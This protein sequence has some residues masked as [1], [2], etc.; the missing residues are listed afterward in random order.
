MFPDSGEA[1]LTVLLVFVGVTFW[2][3]SR[4]RESLRQL[5]VERPAAFISQ[6][7]AIRVVFTIGVL[8]AVLA[9]M[10]FLRGDGAM[11]AASGLGEG[12]SWFVAFDVG[13][14]LDVLAAVWVLSAFRH[15]C[16][17]AKYT[18]HR[19]MRIFARSRRP[20]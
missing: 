19:V 18:A 14:Y 20:V 17:G 4:S 16:G 13:T 7:T 8:A 9:L 2:V 3:L 10:H 12:A 6:L 5:L 15:I 1:M 11:L